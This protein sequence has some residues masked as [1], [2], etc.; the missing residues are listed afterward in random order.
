MSAYSITTRGL[1]QGTLTPMGALL[2]A[3]S[4]PGA[5]YDPSD[6][7]TM[8]QDEAGT[9]PVTAV[10]QPVGRMLDKSGRGNHATQ[11]TTTKRPV[12]SRRVNMLTKTDAISINSPWGVGLA[13]ITIRQNV[14]TADGQNK[15]SGIV[16]SS[17]A[18]TSYSDLV[19]YFSVGAAGVNVGRTYVFSVE[20][21]SDNPQN[22]ILFISDA[23][24]NSYSKTVSI[25]STPTRHTFV[26]S[27]GTG[28]NASATT[29]GVGLGFVPN[30]GEVFVNEPSLTLATDAHLPYQRVN[31]AT[32][33]D[34]DP[35]KFPAYLSFDGVDDAMVTVVN[36][37]L[38]G[39]DK[40][41]AWAGI[42]VSSSSDQ[43]GIWEL[44]TNS[45][46][47]NGLSMQCMLSPFATL[48][49][50]AFGTSRG[51]V[52][53]PGFAPNT[54]YRVCAQYD[55]SAALVK[56]EI[57][58]RKNGVYVSSPIL[59]SS[60]TGNFSSYPLTVMARGYMA[61]YT[62]GCLYSL[63]VRGTQ[64]PLSQIEATELYIKQKMRMP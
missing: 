21:W 14:P 18:S 26:S 42:S 57:R 43:S 37:D 29:I 50:Q 34:A 47:S 12:Y 33:Y 3:A 36:V 61:A 19:Q 32:D 55:L 44:G 46:T 2:F 16:R 1:P 54:A 24:Y 4:E 7:S 39:T 45:T 22:V 10:E 58:L 41:T 56:D 25:N 51:V 23:Y 31:T 17:G 52:D 11:A 63:I 59:E 64:T 5:W 20:L 49:G 30:A 60:G 48:R 53:A 38:S 27:G 8:F 13:G 35:S 62:G 40:V 9:T 6:L 15:A 28:W